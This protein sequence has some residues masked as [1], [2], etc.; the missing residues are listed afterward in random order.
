[1]LTLRDQEPG[2]L[3]NRASL[4]LKWLKDNGFSPTRQYNEPPPSMP[5]YDPIALEAELNDR[6]PVTM[7]NGNELT[8]EADELFANVSKGKTYWK[9]KGG[10]FSQYGVTIWPE[11]L[12]DAMKSGLITE[13]ELDPMRSY[14][15]GGLVACYVENDNGKPQK[16]TRLVNLRR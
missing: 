8:F 14:P 4:A 5:D 9:G 10:R 1:M 3:M 6:A 16:V 12:E 2:K 7:T 15:L 13:E 11:V